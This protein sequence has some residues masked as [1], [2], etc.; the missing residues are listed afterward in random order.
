MHVM[1]KCNTSLRPMTLF[2]T[3]MFI[4][5]LYTSTTGIKTE[6]DAME[7]MAVRDVKAQSKVVHPAG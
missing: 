7:T 1:I 6:I 3:K 2:L 5:T 4:F